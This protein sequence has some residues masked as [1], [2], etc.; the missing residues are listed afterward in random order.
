[1]MAALVSLGIDIPKSDCSSKEE[2]KEYK[3]VAIKK[4]SNLTKNNK[5][6]NFLMGLVALGEP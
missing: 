3:L 5:K 1:M 2:G 6:K 4:N